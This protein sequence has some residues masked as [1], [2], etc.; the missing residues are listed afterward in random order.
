MSGTRLKGLF[1]GAILEMIGPDREADGRTWRNVRDASDR[2]EG[3]IA[4]E[5]VASP[6][7]SPDSLASPSPSR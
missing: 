7:A 3:W 4:A 5:F 6:T 2:T 1:D